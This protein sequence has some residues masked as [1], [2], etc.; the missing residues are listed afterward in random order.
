M[1]KFRK[2]VLHRFE[3]LSPTEQVVLLCATVVGFTFTSTAIIDLFPVIMSVRFKSAAESATSIKSSDVANCVAAF[4][5][6]NWIIETSFVKHE[7]RFAHPIIYLNLRSLIPPDALHQAHVEMIKFILLKESK[8]NSDYYLLLSMHFSH[9][10]ASI[11]LDNTVKAVVTSTKPCNIKSNIMF[12]LELLHFSQAYC[13]SKIDVMILG[14]AI[15]LIRKVLR[16]YLNEFVLTQSSEP[17]SDSYSFCGL[18]TRVF[19]R[20]KTVNNGNFVKFNSVVP[21]EESTYPSNHS[22]TNIV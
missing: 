6:K 19:I 13:S 3:L 10:K 15:L 14:K 12:V 17:A 7:F 9:V 8:L 22:G 18:L 11:A 4:V 2:L 5:L 21:E 16:K 20:G 1:L